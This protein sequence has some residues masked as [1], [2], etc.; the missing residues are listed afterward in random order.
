MTTTLGI[1]TG[2]FNR[3]DHLKSMIASVRANIPTGISYVIT[4]V[5]GGSTDGTI[6]WLT[7][8]PD[9]RPILQ[10]ELLGAIR[11]F[12]EG[13]RATDAEYIVLANDD[14][15][16]VGDGIIRA[17]AHLET[18][19]TCGA[20]AFADNR[21]SDD[22][23]VQM[24]SAF[25]DNDM[26][27]GRN[28]VY[29]QVGM[30]RKWLGDLAGWWGDLDP[31]MARGGTYGGDN[32][33]SARIWERGYTVEAVDGV[34]VQDHVVKDGLRDHNM[35]VEGRI[36]S[37]YYDRYRV[38][39]QIP[40]YPNVA[41][42]QSERLR[43][44]YLPL[45]EPHFGQYKHGLRDAL[46]K[47][48]LVVEWDYLNRPGNFASIVESWQPHLILAQFHSAEVA[49]GELAQARVYAPG[50]V[51]VTWN[52]D[53]HEEPLIGKDVM[54]MLKHV[55]LQLVVNADVLPVYEAAG[56]PAAYWQVAFEPVDEMA[57]PA[58][59]VHDVLFLANAYS[60]ERRKLGRVLRKLPCNVGL[61]GRGWDDANGECLYDF[62]AGRALYRNAKLAISDNQ[63]S[64][65][66]Y[67]SNRLFEALASG[68]CVLQQ[69][70]PGLE[71]L[72]GLVPGTHYV[73]YT[74]NRDIERKVSH[75]LAH[76]DEAA[77]IGAAGR[78]Y[79]LSHH[80]FDA[81]VRELFE[82]LL[83]MAAERK[84]RELA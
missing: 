16:F 77:V 57:L 76:P 80:S 5:D 82:R 59:P 49:G 12:S 61:Y 72:T 60:E 30:F 3:L 8:Q 73:A 48:G 44:L 21:Q 15:T 50:A 78:E 53:V 68:V 64:G 66:A 47:V 22:Y 58:A 13:A 7:E 35:A 79:A 71:E 27:H 75:Y 62:A 67:V 33:L 74:D 14:I 9:C 34:K 19:P 45:Y 1:V 23:A 6:R 52:G 10:G 65:K 42:P 32:Y 43:I 51:V 55:D 83:P 11:A 2:T 84:A 40:P 28:V 69:R 39:P 25:T 63:Y 26:M 29:A 54:E 18:H 4:V 70:V 36:G 41:N 46:A 56:I 24:M 17:L 37:A 38:G 20:V 31:V 81:R